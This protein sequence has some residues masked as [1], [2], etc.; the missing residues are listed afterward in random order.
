MS[1]DNLDDFAFVNLC[2]SMDTDTLAEFVQTTKRA[3]DLCQKILTSRKPVN[4]IKYGALLLLRQ[5]GN[6]KPISQELLEAVKDKV[7]MYGRVGVKINGNNIK[8]GYED[9]RDAEDFMR[10]RRNI[11]V[12]GYKFEILKV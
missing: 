12:K 10:E 4:P 3:H 11:Q 5:R 8:V 1:L 9:A 7:G 2:N 6:V